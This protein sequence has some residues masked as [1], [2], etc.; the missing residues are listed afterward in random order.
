VSVSEG[1][2][3]FLEDCP[4]S[5]TP[6]GDDDISTAYL[7]LRYGFSDGM[8]V[9]IET[10]LRRTDAAGSFERVLYAYH[11]GPDHKDIDA[12]HFR[13]D[14]NKRLK[15]HHVHLETHP[16]DHIPP[17]QVEPRVD[18]IDPFQFVELVRQYRISDRR[19]LPL[20]KV[21]P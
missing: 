3:Q 15:H 18:S 17:S 20:R 14:F 10:R 11:C 8:M 19:A 12:T 13:I 1:E 5:F 6:F 9:R 16:R 21:G 4:P 2:G 7:V